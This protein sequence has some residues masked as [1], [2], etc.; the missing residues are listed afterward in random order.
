MRRTG[1]LVLLALVVLV[2]GSAFAADGSVNFVIGQR[3]LNDDFWSID[4]LDTQTVFGVN[5]DFGGDKWPVHIAV[6]L[7]LSAKSGTLFDAAVADLSF[8]ALWV[9]RKGKLIRPYLGIGVSSV[10]AAIDIVDDDDVDQSF[11][12][13]ANGGVYFQ[14][15]SHFNVGLDVRLLEGTEFELFALQFD[16]NYAQYGILLGIGW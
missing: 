2:S 8:G 10:G 4:D 3:N 5:A 15:F 6:G 7:N 11:G 12:Y 14:L 13:Y 16:A 9:P 1:G